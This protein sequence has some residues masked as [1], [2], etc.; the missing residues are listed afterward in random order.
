MINFALTNAFAFANAK[1]YIINDAPII[2]INDKSFA[3]EKL[4]SLR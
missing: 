1:T 2:T 4:F 3:N